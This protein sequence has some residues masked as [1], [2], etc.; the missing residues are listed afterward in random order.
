M[1]DAHLAEI[2][3]HLN[4]GE[5]LAHHAKGVMPAVG[6]DLWAV[7]GLPLGFVVVMAALA[8]SGISSGPPATEA[9]IM[10]GFFLCGGALIYALRRRFVLALTNMRVLVIALKRFGGDGSRL[11]AAFPRDKTLGIE[12]NTMRRTPVV[13]VTGEHKPFSG[14]VY[15]PDAAAEVSAMIDEVRR[16]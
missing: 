8:V 5:K 13:T 3:R 11:L 9:A 7:V 6:H 14:I 12:L 1:S 4:P 16:R 15:S 10:I 2:A